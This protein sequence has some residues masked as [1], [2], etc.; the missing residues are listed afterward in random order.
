[1]DNWGPPHVRSP[2]PFA[3]TR[4]GSFKLL[5]TVSDTVTRTLHD[6]QHAGAPARA[7]APRGTRPV[8]RGAMEHDGRAAVLPVQPGD[9]LFHTRGHV[10]RRVPPLYK[11]DV[12]SEVSCPLPFNARSPHAAH[13]QTP[14]PPP[15]AAPHSVCPAWQGRTRVGLVGT[16]A[17]LARR[18]RTRRRAP[19]RAPT[20]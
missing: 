11:W 2:I 12:F 10:H 19:P 4:R 18:V 8:R 9:L 13:Q 15:A 14:P 1:M 7:A 6:G 20:T 5:P 3:R 16:S 17:R